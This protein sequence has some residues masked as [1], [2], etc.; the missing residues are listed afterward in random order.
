[1]TTEPHGA[2]TP[3]PNPFSILGQLRNSGSGRGRAPGLVTETPAAERHA[4]WLELFFDLVFVFTISELTHFAE[5]HMTLGGLAQITLLVA[6][7][8]WVW[9]GF[10]YYAD[11]FDANDVPYRFV[12]MSGMF[13]VVV[14]SRTIH[15][16]FNGGAANFAIAYVVLRLMVIGLYTRAWFAVREARPLV[17][18]LLASYTLGVAVWIISI[19]VPAPACYYLWVVALLIEYG[20]SPVAYLTMPAQNVPAQVS[21][22]PERFGLFIIISLGEAIISVAGGAQEISWRLRDVVF[23]LSGFTVVVCMWWLYFARADSEVISRAVSSGRRTSLLLSFVYGYSHILIVL[24]TVIGSASFVLTVEALLEN[25]PIARV[26]YLVSASSLALYI[27]GTVLNHWASPHSLS[28]IQII[29]RLVGAA[30]L[31]VLAVTGVITN[32]ALTVIT[33]AGILLVLAVLE[34]PLEGEGEGVEI[35]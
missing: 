26:I 21:H 8:F 25:E 14:L 23:A 10:A 3:A 2:S 29:I 12:L 13:G 35:T 22:M 34:R 32:P 16:S 9:I 33:A 31:M 28:R 18:R 1:M 7:V 17:S 30:L 19:F 24:A 11:Q 5:D 6:A 4:T 15:D 20:G 27:I